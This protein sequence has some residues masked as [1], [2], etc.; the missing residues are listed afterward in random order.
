MRGIHA[1]LW[2]EI[3]KIR[4]TKI[5]AISIYFF[6]FIGV[7]MGLLMFLSMHPEIA[8]RSATISAKTSFLG[9]SD[10]TAFFELLLQI[11]LTVGVIGSGVV[12]SWG[13]GREFS[14]RVVKDLLAL[15]VSRSTIVISKLI[16]LII[17]SIILSISLLIAAMLTGLIVKIPGWSEGALFPF[18]STYFI[19]AILNALLITP[20]AFAAS[21]GRGY[22]LPISFVI[23]LLIL[24]QL[25]FVG[26][27]ALSFYFPWAIPALYSGVGGDT[28]PPPGF[29]SYLI[30]GLTIIIGLVGT[31]IWWRCADHK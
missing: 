22:M 1:A 29:I 24:T 6:I 25:I 5:F 26:L 23:L 9:G 14:D 10:W 2:I 21:I 11:I 27:P 16:T 30:Y 17:W 31:I 13:F 8:N 7:M 4:R 15:P 20:V 18:L 3:L 19:C 28:V 12:T